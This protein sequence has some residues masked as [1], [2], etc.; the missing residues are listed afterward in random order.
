MSIPVPEEADR[1]CGGAMDTVTVV[2]VTHES[3]H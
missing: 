2:V 3:A 1:L